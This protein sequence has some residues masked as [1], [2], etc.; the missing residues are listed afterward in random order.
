MTSRDGKRVIAT[1]VGSLVAIPSES[2]HESTTTLT[3]LSPTLPTAQQQA[4]PSLS[5]LLRAPGWW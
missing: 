2:P 3:H 1:V 4:N 5:P